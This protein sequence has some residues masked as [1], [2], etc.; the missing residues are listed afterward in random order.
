MSER[1]SQEVL[2]LAFDSTTNSFNTNA[3]LSLGSGSLSISSVGIDQTTP[4]ANEV[5]VINPSGSIIPVAL[6][7][8]QISSLTPLAAGY[9]VTPIPISVSGSGSCPLSSDSTS[10]T[11]SGSIKGSAGIFY[12]MLGYNSKASAQFIQIFNSATVPADTTVPV[13]IVYVPATS[14]FSVSFA[15]FG[16]PFSS[17]ISWSNSASGSVKYQGAADCWINAQYL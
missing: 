7:T 17:G 6:P 8:S 12:G 3:T 13:V 4:H 1:S 11:A 5:K 15:P 2:N 10:Y 14:N 9:T 16:K